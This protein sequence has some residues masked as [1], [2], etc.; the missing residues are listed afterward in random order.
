MIPAFVLAMRNSFSVCADLQLQLGRFHP[1]A[2]R[3][4]C[5]S[6]LCTSDVFF[7]G[8][9]GHAPRTGPAAPCPGPGAGTSRQMTL[10]SGTGMI[11][12]VEIV[13]LTIEAAAAFAILAAAIAWPGSF[14]APTLVATS[15]PPRSK[16]PQNA[17]SPNSSRSG[18]CRSLTSPGNCCPTDLAP[19]CPTHSG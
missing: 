9:H 8:R 16:L 2:C 4:T 5:R 19:G 7:P 18:P 15:K 14:S 11:F 1:P 12:H 13:R 3:P 17:R 6:R 10:L